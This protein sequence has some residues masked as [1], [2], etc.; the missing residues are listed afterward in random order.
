[1]NLLEKLKKLQT[2]L[3]RLIELETRLKYLEKSYPIRISNDPTESEIANGR[4]LHNFQYC[5]DVSEPNY[6][7]CTVCG[8][9]VNECGATE[10][11]WYCV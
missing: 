1:M 11:S 2:L 8:V 10:D 3:Q 9:S 4:S 5:P 6:L 7:A